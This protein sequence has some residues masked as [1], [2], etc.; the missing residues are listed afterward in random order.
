M[1]AVMR[2][3]REVDDP[4]ISGN[5]DYTR[6]LR[7]LSVWITLWSTKDPWVAYDTL[8]NVHPL[9]AFPAVATVQMIQLR[10]AWLAPR[11]DPY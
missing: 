6:H 9:P 11:H 5:A 7:T 2:F 1:K 10:D 8:H 4:K 3:F